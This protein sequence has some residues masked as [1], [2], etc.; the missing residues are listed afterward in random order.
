MGDTNIGYGISPEAIEP[1]GSFTISYDISENIPNTLREDISVI[2]VQII[3]ESGNET[4]FDAAQLDAVNALIPQVNYQV[5]PGSADQEPEPEPNIPDEI[6]ESQMSIIRG[7]DGEDTVIIDNNYIEFNL[8]FENDTVITKSTN[9]KKYL[10]S[11]ECFLSLILMLQSIMITKQ[12][13]KI[14]S[15]IMISPLVNLER[16]YFGLK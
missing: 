12:L 4:L 1:D 16:L 13:M 7:D 11:V 3:D 14:L 8:F 15:L 9:Q 6:A 10:Q 2:R 5:N